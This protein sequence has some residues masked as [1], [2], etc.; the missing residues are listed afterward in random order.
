MLVL[1]T[2]GAGYIG[3][4]TLRLLREHGYDTIAIDTLEYGRRA[5]LGPTPLIEGDLRDT[6]LLG[7]LFAE[8]PI[9]AVIHFA[10]YKAV[11]ES[12]QQPGRYFQ[13]NVGGT[14]ALLE[15]MQRAGVGRIVFSSTAA[16]YGMPDELPVRETSPLRP[17]NPYGASKLM[18]EQILRWFDACHGLRSICLRYFN[19]VG[20]A[21]DASIGE[22]P[23]RAPNL[24]PVVLKAALGQLPCVEVFGTDYPTP[25]GTAIRDYIHVQDLADAHIRALQYLARHDRSAT[26]NLGTGQGASVQQVLDLARQIT[27]ADIPVRYTDRRPGDPAAVWADNT[28]AMAELGWQPHHSLADMIASAWAWFQAYSASQHTA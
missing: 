16:V 26:F 13:N 8:R 5:A 7:R 17:A 28:L 18:A 3:S 25:D 14:L 15:A 10:A 6:R 22:D 9:D 1:V 19:V 20:A 21:P 2:G 4:H 27:G 12:M 23:A 11:G 24:V